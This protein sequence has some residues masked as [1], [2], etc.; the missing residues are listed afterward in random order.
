MPFFLRTTSL[1]L[2]LAVFAGACGDDETT[3]TDT[4]DS[5]SG[6]GT[7]ADREFWSTAVTIDGEPFAL[8]DGT[9][10]TL[11][12]DAASISAGAG[13]NNLGG[14]YTIDGDTLFVGDVFQTEMGCDPQRHAQDD[15][16]I[17]LLT[18]APTLTLDGDSL[19]VATDT[20][21]IVLVDKK[22]A[23]PD[24]ALEATTWEVTG[25]FD[26]V[27]AWSY[28]VDVASTLTFREGSLEVVDACGTT[29]IPTV[30]T[31]AGVELTPPDTW[32]ACFGA[33]PE[34][35]RDLRR[36]LESGFVTAEIDGRNLR[37]SSAGDLGVTA[38]AGA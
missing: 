6:A 33:A 8:V 28:A 29:S 18:A 3:T 16:V 17:D 38:V 12:F 13:C 2:A 27:A 34:A 37:L 10:I 5:G 31:D 7:I 25:F 4:D 11:R 21:T 36:A 22:V 15:L 30:T 35:T 32:P 26:E 20:T 19:T 9:R 24:L 1:L 23:E 14:D